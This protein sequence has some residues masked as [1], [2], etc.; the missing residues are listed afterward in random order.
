LC[1]WAGRYAVK[2]PMRIHRHDC[3]KPAHQAEPW[4][5]ASVVTISDEPLP[6]LVAVESNRHR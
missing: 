2:V 3:A 5:L 4:L 6:V 1:A